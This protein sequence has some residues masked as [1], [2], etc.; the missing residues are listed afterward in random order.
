MGYIWGDMLFCLMDIPP[1]KD[2]ARQV[3]TVKPKDKPYKLCDDGGT[4]PFG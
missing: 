2:G 3:D 4:L 1:M